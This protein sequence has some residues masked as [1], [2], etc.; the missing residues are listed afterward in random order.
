M[1][2]VRCGIAQNGV[3]AGDVRKTPEVDDVPEFCAA[4]GDA[5]V[6]ARMDGETVARA[7]WADRGFQQRDDSNAIAGIM[8]QNFSPATGIEPG[9]PCE[10]AEAEPAGCKAAQPRGGE[11]PVA[12]EVDDGAR[13]LEGGVLE[14]DPTARVAK[15][16]VTMWN[17]VGRSVPSTTTHGS[18]PMDTIGVP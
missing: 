15:R 9:G 2:T 14:I 18:P 6:A 7:D 12:Q 1:A 13:A 16:G 11:G 10:C 3:L 8:G 17:A 4:G 5:L